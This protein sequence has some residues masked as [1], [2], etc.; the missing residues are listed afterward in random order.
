M[1]PAD[2]GWEPAAVRPYPDL[3]ACPLGSLVAGSLP[4]VSGFTRRCIWGGDAAWGWHRPLRHGIW[5][6]MREQRT[7]D[8]VP[9]CPRLYQPLPPWRRACPSQSGRLFYFYGNISPKTFQRE[10]GAV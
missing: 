6:E 5:L 4:A 8:E 2:E 1:A 3:H 9:L 7:E 10:P